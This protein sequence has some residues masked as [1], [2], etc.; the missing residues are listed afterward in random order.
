[1]KEGE[2]SL[3]RVVQENILFLCAGM[4][5]ENKLR[6]QIAFSKEFYIFN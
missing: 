2:L 1:M 4:S 3:C 5:F 6:E